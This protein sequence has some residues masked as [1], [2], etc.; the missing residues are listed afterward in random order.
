MTITT[1][2]PV[3]DVTPDAPDPEAI[4]RVYL[5]T[6][7]QLGGLGDARTFDWH[8]DQQVIEDRYIALA[9][10]NEKA[11]AAGHPGHRVRTWDAHV[12]A[13]WSN[14]QVTD[15]LDETFVGSDPEGY[16]LRDS[17]PLASETD[18]LN[19]AIFALNTWLDPDASDAKDLDR[20][21]LHAKDAIARLVELRTQIRDQ[22]EAAPDCSTEC[23]CPYTVTVAG[24]VVASIPRE[25]VENDH[26]LVVVSSPDGTTLAGLDLTPEGV[27]VG[28]W[29][30]VLR[31]PDDAE[32]VSLG[33]VPFP[34]TLDA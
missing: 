29:P 26:A 25:Q 5:V 7:D 12:V 14:Q 16:P 21:D 10:D 30:D 11:T 3:G 27:T 17:H 20:L 18:A 28:H 9:E 24:K 2:T 15:Y 13:G 8:P 23:A 33:T 34:A 19:L 4:R 22:Q 31:H 1:L 32:W 6:V